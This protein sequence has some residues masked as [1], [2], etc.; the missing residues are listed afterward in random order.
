M[1]SLQNLLVFLSPNK[2]FSGLYGQLAKI[3]IENSV[4]LGWDRND[5]ILVTNFPW[6]YNRVKAIVVGDEHY[7]KARP[8]SIKTS[9]IPHLIDTKVI[10][11]GK[12]YWNHDLDAFQTYPFKTTDLGL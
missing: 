12:L 5:I 7:C 6:E 2:S 3:Q 10:K 4:S 9:I 1:G 11:K 8:R